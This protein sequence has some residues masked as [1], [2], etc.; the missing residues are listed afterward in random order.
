[1]SKL[2]GGLKEKISWYFWRLRVMTPAEYLS[3]AR[4]VMLRLTL[5]RGLRRLQGAHLD[6]TPSGKPDLPDPN[7]APPGL[8]EALA[9][10]AG[11]LRSGQWKVF[12]SRP[13]QTEVPPDWFID[14]VVG[15]SLK[16]FG[17]GSGDHRRLPEGMDARSIWELS[18]WI[19]VCRLA[20]SAFLNGKDED[21]EAA[22]H[23]LWDWVEKNP[24]GHGIHWASPLETGLRLIQFVWIEA[25]LEPGG[26]TKGTEWGELRQG[27]VPVHFWWTWR[28]RSFGSS[29]NNHLL[30]ELAAVLAAL[31]RWPGLAE[32]GVER[33]TVAGELFDQI[34]L[35]FHPDGGNREQALH[36]HL[37]ALEL[38]QQALWMLEQCGEKVPD[39]VRERMELA[40]RFF[41]TLHPEEEPWDYGD[42]D[43]ALVVPLSRDPGQHALEWKA[44]IEGG[45]RGEVL[46]F[47]LGNAGGSGSWETPEGWQLFPESG[48]AVRRC[49]DL[50][51]RADAS[52]MGLEPMAAHGHV[53]ALHLSVWK[54]DQAVVIDPGTGGYFGDAVVRTWL[55]SPEAH[56][57]PVMEEAGYPVRR[58]VFLW[59][60]LHPMPEMRLEGGE[61][62]MHLTLPGARFERRVVMDEEG[63]EVRDRVEPVGGALAGRVASFTVA[64]TFAPGWSWDSEGRLVREDLVLHV[65]TEPSWKRCE[66][67]EPRETSAPAPGAGL[68]SP[69]YRHLA[70]GPVLELE[71]PADGRWHGVR[72][73]G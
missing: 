31:C 45:R 69:H 9:R 39:R 41:A 34:L 47:W 6:L 64:W 30:G 40:R 48:M 7:L 22:L 36:Y 8:A 14:P 10:E 60:K 46:R 73:E 58:G 3:R 61:L 43:D 59:T 33:R 16:D 5:R 42:S 63:W 57:G 37:F 32:L 15:K 55:A 52:P 49:G 11:E 38:C 25:L 70:S 51:V 18:R 21:A 54:G 65:D 72:V 28:H 62:I 35:Q 26:Y 1:M 27:I 12:G 29:A 23:W 71:A 20:Q 4:S 56:N 2:A 53:D 44:W 66:K 68:C 17:D 67:N 50:L 19:Q 24:P 13:F